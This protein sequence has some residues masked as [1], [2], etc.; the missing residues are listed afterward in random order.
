MSIRHITGY[1]TNTEIIDASKEHT[2]NYL[3][4]LFTKN[5][6]ILEMLVINFSVE[7]SSLTI[8]ILN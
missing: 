5:S 3:I 8:N 2:Y 7:L 1:F 6:T 4:M